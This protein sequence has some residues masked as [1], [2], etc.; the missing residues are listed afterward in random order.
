MRKTAWV[1]I[2]VLLISSGVFALNL[3]GTN[4]NKILEQIRAANL[5][6][7]KAVYWNPVVDGI[8]QCHLCPRRCIIADGQRGACGARVNIKGTL[9]SLVYGKVI[10]IHNDPIEKKPFAHFLPGTNA[11]SIA[12]AGCNL[13]CLFCQNW[14]I[15]QTAPEDAQ[16]VALDPKNI[17][18]LAE[19]YKIPSIAYTYTEPTIF[20]E[21][22]YDTA[23]LAKARGIRNVMHSCG[24]I[25]PEPLK[26]LL[27]YM[28]AADIDLKGFSE[29]FYNQY[30]SASLQPVLDTLV[31]IKESGTWLEITHLVIPN[32]N[33]D[34]EM[35]TK[36]C[37][38][39]KDNLGPDVP[40]HLSA[41][42]PN[43]M[44]LDTTPTPIET[45]EELYA[46]T[47][48]VGLKYVYIG[49]IYGNTKEST[50]C[51]KDGKL[52]IKRQGYKIL[53]NNI[54]DGKCKFDGTIIPGVWK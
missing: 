38:W 12:T 2:A 26:E 28:D 23:K 14:Q 1:L 32:A 22:M 50:Y 47:K 42:H 45:M 25:N 10:A 54:I 49:N 3:K 44:M 21:F 51:P 6:Q 15:S 5:S 36:M 34:P 46:I 48:E 13:R 27:K 31:T 39:I 29:E 19:Q 24:Y 41:F 17:V 20:Y 33:D 9:Y 7:I 11:L 40:L 52:L 4:L 18:D 8:V 16:N 43:Y 53:E 37:R 35:F 30:C